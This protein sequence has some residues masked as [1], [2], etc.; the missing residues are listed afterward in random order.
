[1]EQEKEPSISNR[2]QSNAIEKRHR[3]LTAIYEHLEEKGPIY[4]TTCGVLGASVGAVIGR[5]YFP[6]TTP[7]LYG[8]LSMIGCVGG[9]VGPSI[10]LGDIQKDIRYE[11]GK[12]EKY[13]DKH[14]ERDH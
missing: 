6:D 11:L 5:H 1:M 14:I 2:N 12:L 10:T 8:A 13:L 3:R 9:F 7:L 4:V